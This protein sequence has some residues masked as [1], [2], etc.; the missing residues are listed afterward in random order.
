[1][2]A[3]RTKEPGAQDELQRNQLLIMA[4]RE[5][6]GTLSSGGGG[7][8]DLM[9]FLGTNLSAGLY[10][11][12][13]VNRAIPFSLALRLVNTF[14]LNLWPLEVLSSCQVYFGRASDM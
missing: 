4:I 13:S 1:M 7:R 8:S 11:V 14:F 12:S 2:T 6:G 3:E 10:P 9:A 5:L